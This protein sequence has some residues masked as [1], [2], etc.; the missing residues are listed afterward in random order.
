MSENGQV[1]VPPAPLQLDT[2][3]VLEI[4]R[5]ENPQAFDL[6]VRRA[7]IEAQERL[8]EELRAELSGRGP[9]TVP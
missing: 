6:A 5:E 3:R 4:I 9:G 7:T 2:S 1:V 8:I